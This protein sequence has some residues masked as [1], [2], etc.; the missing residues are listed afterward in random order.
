MVRPSVPAR[1]RGEE[2][3]LLFWR[4]PHFS[5]GALESYIGK[6]EGVYW[7][8]DPGDRIWALV[9]DELVPP[10]YAQL[11]GCNADAKGDFIEL[12]LGG[13]QHLLDCETVPAPDSLLR[14][15]HAARLLLED[16]ARTMEEI[17]LREEVP[18]IKQLERRADGCFVT[19]RHCLT[20]GRQVFARRWYA[21]WNAALSAASG[22]QCQDQSV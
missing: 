22:H 19:S 15:V 20:C 21:T 3:A 6:D 10:D 5:D 16:L 11:R 12:T 13:C 4:Y 8:R 18:L 2:T 7:T 14:C 17:H 1:E 9:F